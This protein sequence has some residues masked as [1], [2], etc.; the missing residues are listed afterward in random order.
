[1]S[2]ARQEEEELKPECG[3]GVRGKKNGVIGGVG[4]GGNPREV[5]SR[6]KAV[7]VLPRGGS[8]ILDTNY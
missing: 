3:D 7:F 6:K 2:S 5:R 8:G 1:M 4:V